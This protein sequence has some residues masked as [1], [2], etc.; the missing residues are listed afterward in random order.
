[1]IA[2]ETTATGVLPAWTAPADRKIQVI[3]VF[4]ELFF[5]RKRHRTRELGAAAGRKVRLCEQ[6]LGRRREHDDLRVAPTAA[7]SASG[8]KPRGPAGAPIS[9]TV[10]HSVSVCP[11]RQA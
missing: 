4:G 11:G 2:R 6:H 3:D 8:P 7:A 10:N 9:S 1:M 5:E